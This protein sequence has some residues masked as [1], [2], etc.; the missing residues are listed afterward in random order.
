MLEFLWP[1]LASVAVTL[2]L[3]QMDKSNLNLRKLKNFMERGKKELQEITREKKEEL[4][5]ATTRFDMLLIQSEQQVKTLNDQAA[6]GEKRLTEVETGLK[7]LQEMGGEIKE[8]ESITYSIK[9]QIHLVHHSLNR[10]GEEAKRLKRIESD[11]NRL[12]QKSEQQL[13]HFDDSVKQQSGEIF[14]KIEQKLEVIAHDATDFQNKLREELIVKQD[15]LGQAAEQNFQTLEQNLKQAS[16]Q[17]A[18]EIVQ[19]NDNL[20][21]QADNL[22]H[23]IEKIDSELKTELPA[24]MQK[25]STEQL[26]AAD[27]V[28]AELNLAK[29]TIEE[30]SRAVDARIKQVFEEIEGRRN[31]LMQ[32]VL[33]DTE[34]LHQEFDQLNLDS[35]EKKDEIVQAA[36]SEAR[37]TQANIEKFQDLYANARETLF[38]EASRREREI[39]ERMSELENNH[40]QLIEKLN[41]AKHQHLIEI[42]ESIQESLKMIRGQA[43]EVFRKAADLYQDKN[44]EILQSFENLED[45]IASVSAAEDER[46]E[47]TGLRIEQLEESVKSEIQIIL[48]K[49]RENQEK[50][51]VDLETRWNS[52]V[53]DLDLRMKEL[54]DNIQEIQNQSRNYIDE[55][56]N[57]LNQSVNQVEERLYNLKSNMEQNWKSDSESIL[58]SF[59]EASH[60]AQELFQSADH[61]IEENNQKVQSLIDHHVQTFDKVESELI[62]KLNNNIDDQWDRMRQLSEEWKEDNEVHTSDVLNRFKEKVENKESEL[63]RRMENITHSLTDMRRTLETKQETVIDQILQE[64]RV[65]EKEIGQ[66]TNEKVED[67]ESTVDQHF[68]DRKSRMQEIAKE[69]EQQLASLHEN[70][71]SQSESSLNSLEKELSDYRREQR[72]S[73][74]EFGIESDRLKRELSDMN[75]YLKELKHESEYLENLQD[76]ISRIRELSNELDK[77]LSLADDKNEILESIYLKVEDLNKLRVK[78][79]NELNQVA[80]KRDRMDSIEEQVNLILDLHDQIEERSAALNDY[81]EK[82]ERLM[83]SHSLINKQQEKVDILMKDFLSQQQLIENTITVMKGQSNSMNSITEDVERLIAIFDTTD[84]KANQLREEYQTL[85]ANYRSLQRQAADLEKIERRFLE[86]EDLLTDIDS[87]RNQLQNL[88]DQYSELQGTI[89][90]SVSAISSIE[91]NAESKIQQLSQFYSAIKDKADQ[92]PYGVSNGVGDKKDVVLRLGRLGWSAQEIANKVQMDEGTIQAILSTF[93]RQPLR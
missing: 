34:R 85:D 66:L 60:K 40:D 38:H 42:Q 29:V 71:I 92:A 10:L 59:Q 81:N 48:Q 86:V 47:K 72:D 52:A 27:E 39:L 46:L 14:Q 15:R 93:S 9:D 51:L 79:D 62:E 50:Y 53:T 44:I 70:A 11:I 88:R 43:E 16:S 77:R 19:Q 55:R 69:T 30:E 6:E 8:L 37:K 64:K 78:I 41:E 7:S 80:K 24:R 32:E 58:K 33:A 56:T 83:D 84:E 68:Q 82:L 18:E 1:F 22:R 57:Q 13:A 28:K 90:Q 76:Q 61:K 17:L 23:I 21:Q 4:K 49:G 3:R 87:R 35:I 31:E 65:I 12:N 75:K 73:Q 26:A 54:D 20:T 36:R 25:L 2:L 89:D 45:K 91:Q 63:T 74:E 67:F 5:D